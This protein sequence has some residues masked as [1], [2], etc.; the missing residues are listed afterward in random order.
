MKMSLSAQSLER[1]AKTDKLADTLLL[2]V[3]IVYS[4][5]TVLVAFFINHHG[6]QLIEAII[7]SAVVLGI[8][9]FG[10]IL[11]A[12]K[13]ACRYF[14]ATSLMLMVALHIH[15]AMGMLEFH[16]GVFL[17]LALLLLY[18]DWKPIVVAALVIAMHH[19]VVDRLQA[20]GF[21]IFCLEEANFRQILIHAAYVVVQ[22]GFQ[23]KIAL[24]LRGSE[25]SAY[26]LTDKLQI[27]MKDLGATVRDVKLHSDAVLS[28]ANTIA[29]TGEYLA[30][31]SSNAASR[32]HQTAIT[33]EA[34]SDSIKTNTQ[35]SISADE[36]IT[37]A[38]KE[39]INGR[40]L[41]NEI[42]SVMSDIETSSNKISAITE[43]INGISFQTNILALNA[44]VEAARA[45]EQGRGFAVVASEVR[46]LAQR[47]GQ[48]AK[49]IE[50]LIE[51]S[52]NHMRE[53]V[54]F[55]NT[56]NSTIRNMAVS[57]EDAS[58]LVADISQNTVTQAD[59]V[60]LVN[61]SIKTLEE[62][63]KDNDLAAKSSV[64]I[65]DDLQSHAVSL[66]KSVSKI[67]IENDNRD[68]FSSSFN[69]LEKL[70]IH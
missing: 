63:V 31:K 68:D 23:I 25:M 58:K 48:A 32:L 33:I 38:A 3:L 54:K 11:Y 42:V 57:V 66:D 36:L 41:V 8:G 51:T 7:S 40:N 50:V 14:M 17:T 29:S 2:Y 39:A 28:S 16:F 27:A 6:A 22:T 52:V 26:H 44:A 45:G 34:L 56:A 62:V 24:M 30:D 13:T 64:E 65:A 35:M 67:N 59:Q 5:V 20:A 9:V 55:V 4:I 12:G 53:G 47:A 60:E 10:F 18:R 37:S 19:V 46:T 49:E 70:P 1:K 21:N 43:V 15:F 61:Q 69:S